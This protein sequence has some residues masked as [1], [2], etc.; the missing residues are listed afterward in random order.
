MPSI[1]T[2]TTDFEER[3]PYAAS[4]K[5]VLCARCPG[6]QVID[7]THQIPRHNIPEGALFIAG[8]VPYFPKGTIHVVAVAS[9]QRPI[10][11]SLGGQIVICP[12]NG[13]ITMLAERYPIDR[14]RDHML[15]SKNQGLLRLLVRS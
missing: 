9:G 1:V 12:D 4:A 5:G 6:V 11:A 7:L 13:V 15:L 3:E 10:A 8:A 2:L 14:A